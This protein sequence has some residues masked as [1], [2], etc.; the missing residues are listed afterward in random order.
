[1]IP[2]TTKK[3]YPEMLLLVPLVSIDVTFTAL[4]PAFLSYEQRCLA[5][6][7]IAVLGSYA[8]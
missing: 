8:T 6:I 4:Y 3:V 7:H 2:S 5:K 1:M